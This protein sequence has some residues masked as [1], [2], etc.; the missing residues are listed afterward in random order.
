MLRTNDKVVLPLLA[1]VKDVRASCKSSS[2]SYTLLDY[3][4]HSLWLKYQRSMELEKSLESES[5][6]W[7]KLPRYLSAHVIRPL[8]T[9]L[10]SLD[11][12]LISTC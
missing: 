9:M 5:S 10:I 1:D 8:Q 6:V 12:Y 11:R 3:L 4:I 7:E 2:A